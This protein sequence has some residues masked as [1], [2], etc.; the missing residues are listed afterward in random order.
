MDST[1]A[2]LENSFSK[3]VA[4]ED[5]MVSGLAPGRLAE[6]LIVGKSTFGRSLT[7]NC[8]NAIM[9][10]PRIAA[11]TRVVMTGLRTNGSVI[12]MSAI[13]GIALPAREP[14]QE[15]ANRGQGECPR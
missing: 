14:R 3:G 8:L 1:P 15:A 2:M 9:P 4:T 6:T 7:G 13:P 10:N 5:A 12:F 11:M